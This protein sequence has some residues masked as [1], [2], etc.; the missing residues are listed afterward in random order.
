MNHS[1]ILLA[2]L[3]LVACS[4][5][6]QVIHSSSTAGGQGQGGSTSGGQ[7]TGGST[8]G[9]QGMGGASSAGGSSSGGQS[10]SG[11]SSTGGQG[12]TGGVSKAGSGGTSAGGSSGGTGADPAGTVGSVVCGGGSCDLIGSICCDYHNAAPACLATGTNC[13]PAVE[14]FCDGPEDCGNGDVC[15]GTIV[16]QGNT[17]QYLSFQCQATCGARDQQV[18]CGES[19]A[20]P[21]GGTCVVSPLQPP[22]KDCSG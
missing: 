22:Y 13:F 2:A 12:N 17:S 19:G 7:G 18:I 9:G 4:G 6:D 21:F 20:C 10:S 14:V 1:I 16:R 3:I 5:N 15:C 11:G 8:S